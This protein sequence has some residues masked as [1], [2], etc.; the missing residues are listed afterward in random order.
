[1]SNL[2]ELYQKHCPYQ[3]TNHIQELEFTFD[4]K[5]LRKELFK[6]IIDNKFGFSTVSLK[7]PQGETN[8]ISSDEILKTGAIAITSIG[9]HHC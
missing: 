3:I 2:I 5:R 1:M 7:L 4:I 8:Y 6:F 9:I